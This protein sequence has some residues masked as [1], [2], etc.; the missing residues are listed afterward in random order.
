MAKSK[1]N[2]HFKAYAD[3][4]DRAAARTHARDVSY[5]RATAS[6]RTTERAAERATASERDHSFDHFTARTHEHAPFEDLITRLEASLQE[7]EAMQ[8]KADEAAI[9]AERTAARAADSPEAFGA[10]RSATG[11]DP[12]APEAPQTNASDVPQDGDAPEKAPFEDL[13]A[14][15]EASVQEHDE[16]H[17]DHSF[18]YDALPDA[19]LAPGAI[20]TPAP[21]ST[22]AFAEASASIWPNTSRATGEP[23]TSSAPRSVTRFDPYAP[24]PLY[25]MAQAAGQILFPP[26][27]RAPLAPAASA[28]SPSWAHDRGD[29]ERHVGGRALH[30]DHADDHARPT[31][32]TAAPQLPVTIQDAPRNPIPHQE[33]S[34]TATKR[35]TLQHQPTMVRPTALGHVPLQAVRTQ[36]LQRQSLSRVSFGAERE[37]LPSLDAMKGVDLGPNLGIYHDHSVSLERMPMRA[38]ALR[39]LESSAASASQ[40]AASGFVSFA[41]PVAP[42]ARGAATGFSPLGLAA[43]TVHVRSTVCT[44][45]G[46]SRSF[47]SSSR[48][49]SSSFNSS[50]ATSSADGFSSTDRGTSRAFEPLAAPKL[51][52]QRLPMQGQ[53]VELHPI[54]AMQRP[55]RTGMSRRAARNTARPVTR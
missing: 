47:R 8:A 49:A 9:K 46:D 53:Q 12:Y 31:S 1:S 50:R 20:S 24:D 29:R 32:L 30:V 11:F 26:V 51:A 17:A 7:I 33:L 22:L 14:R 25:A 45:H 37:K 13:I 48:K 16:A 44:S 2:S 5:A 21:T 38:S 15:L 28:G 23:R 18:V 36:P 39:P 34:S 19:H 43:G 52:E 10:P 27:D 35:V 3:S 6:E 54:P 41:S 40:E 4:A 42:V 55:V